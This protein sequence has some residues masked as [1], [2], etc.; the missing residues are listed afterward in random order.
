MLNLGTLAS[1]V[2]IALAFSGA[3]SAGKQ[4]CRDNF[5][6]KVQIIHSSDNESSF[7]DPNTLEEKIL[8]YSTVTKGLQILA[9]DECIP[10]LHM[11]AGDHTIP[12]PFYQAS[13]EVFD[14][15][16]IGDIVM[17]NAMGLKAN[18]MGNHEF[19]GGINEFAYMLEI[20]SYPF[21]AANLD[22]SNVVLEDGTPA[23]KIGPD[24]RA[25][26]ASR[27][28]VVKSCFVSAGGQKIGFIGRAPADF[29]NVIEDPENTLG[30]L[31][32]VGG[33]D[34]ETNQPLV[35]AVQQVL[36]QVDLLEQRQVDR[37]VLIDHAQDFTGDPLSANELRGIDIIVAAGTTGFMAQSEA[38]GPFNLLR[39]EDTAE[40]DYPT[41][42]EDMDGNTVLVVN[43]DQ[44][45]R[46]VGNLIVEFDKQGHLVGWD[47]RSGPVATTAEGVMAMEKELDISLA[48][49][50]DVTQTFMQLQNTAIIQDA[51]TVVGTTL[52]PLN[53]QR[54]DVRSRETNLGR[55]AADSTI[56]F[57]QN[58]GFPETDIAFK[59]GGG[60]RDSILGPSIIRLTIQAALAFDNKLTVLEM[61]GDQVLAAMEN[62]VSRVPALDGRFP[63][64]AGVQMDYDA[65]YQAIEGLPSVT[66]PSRVRNLTI[67]KH[68]GTVVDM[69]VNGVADQAALADTFV[70]A[71]NSFTATGG[72]GFAAFAA[73][74]VMGA[75]D[76]G[77]QAILEDYISDF[78][79]G[80][81]DLP[82]PPGDSR[83]V[84]LDP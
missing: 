25:C 42:R 30:G 60:I 16:G 18:G 10:S 14:E 57:A 50:S 24:A 75:T 32:F 58:D 77:E 84:R 76:T 36:Q 72:D 68:D 73:A 61:T 40:A 66:V 9:A 59:N 38:N 22:F 55:L 17:Y 21:I 6:N 15:P 29:F 45:Y 1:A 53:G 46:Y 83:V 20:A 33:R 47:E 69:V 27:G 65:T 63:Q 74:T 48:P 13:E 67:T 43:S 34:P 12:G 41:V 52:S 37:I 3:A 8:N 81:V 31:D 64:V 39:P 4:D 5:R 78:L 56:W 7:Q 35:S 26:A 54:A 49:H 70:L 62:S 44:Q 80:T 2:A 11:T 82:D 28:K 71:T 79:G 19:D 23:I 51:F